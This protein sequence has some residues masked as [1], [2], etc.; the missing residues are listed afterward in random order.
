M[1]RECG[2]GVLC[3]QIG[4]SRYQP[5]PSC[6]QIA[7]PSLSSDS[8]PLFV[9]ADSSALL[10]TAA[11]GGNGSAARVLC[12]I[13]GQSDKNTTNNCQETPGPLVKPVS[14]SDLVCEL[15]VAVNDDALMKRLCRDLAAMLP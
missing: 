9:H 12:I 7:L 14:L 4:P 5:A 2:I 10:L 1:D 13:S 11:A 3:H 15:M 8:T 6:H